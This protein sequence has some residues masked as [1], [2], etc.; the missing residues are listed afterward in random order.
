MI[1]LEN[2]VSLHAVNHIPTL[3][4][5]KDY[6]SIGIADNDNEYVGTGN[7]KEEK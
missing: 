1:N 4:Y 6:I 5:E 2:A 3:N 7:G